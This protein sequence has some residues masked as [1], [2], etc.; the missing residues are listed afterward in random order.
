M[1]DESINNGF[2]EKKYKIV[3]G[4]EIHVELL[5]ESKM[6]C[7]CSTKFGEKENS[8][9][10]P[11]CFGM[12]GTLPVLNYEAIELGI[13]TALT[14]NCRIPSE[15]IFVR[16]S[17]FYPDL[18]KN[19]QIS[20]YSQP[21]ASDGYLNVNNKKIGIRR[22]HLEEDTGKLIHSEKNENVS[23]IDFNRSGIPLMEIV[24]EPEISSPEEAEDFLLKLKKFLKYIEVSDCNMEEGSL[25]CDANI[26][27]K[28]HDSKEL[29]IKTEIKNMN[30]FKSVRKALSFEANRHMHLLNENN[31]VRQETRLWDETSQTTDSMRIKE[32]AHD[33]RYFPEPDI[34][35]VR[36]SRDTVEKISLK[37]GELPS[38]REKRFFEQ[39]NL[40]GYNVSVITSEKKLADYF[41]ETASFYKEPKIV[42]NWL[43]T[44]L[45]GILKE[46]NISINTCPI[47]PK[48]FAELIELV[49]LKK[50]TATSGK[51]VLLEMF[52]TGKT[53]SEIVKD[54]QLVQIQDKDRIEELVIEV[55]NENS[56]AVKDYKNGKEQAV[57]F[58]VGMVMKKS[59][60]KADPVKT[61]EILLKKL[62]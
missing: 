30:S 32:E 38:E 22:V 19:F 35:P 5:T 50:I 49:D 51:E 18:P 62:L 8:Q 42:S 16:K 11:V 10:C 31:K 21:L 52:E 34:P 14:L 37:I 12:P 60:G 56:S 23:L 36:I 29:G 27:I 15:C 6:F 2:Y 24:T 47:S 9:I 3:I 40:S 41:E 33:Y 4:L 59:R 48:N 25:R 61:K 20:Q 13:K 28:P 45:L 53:A 17:Y 54:R 26:S 1:A 55:I 7:S 39:Y 57:S 43:Q 46:K 58:L 44:V